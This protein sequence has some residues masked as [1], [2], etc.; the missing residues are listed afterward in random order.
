MV[1]MADPDANERTY[2]LPDGETF[3]GFVEKSAT[4]DGAQIN[5]LV[6]NKEGKYIL[7]T[8]CYSKP[9]ELKDFSDNTLW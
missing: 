8:C 7:R 4:I 3:I 1:H 9:F 6:K 2:E 5:F